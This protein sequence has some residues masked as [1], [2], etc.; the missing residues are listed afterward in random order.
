MI[1]GDKGKT[2]I[3]NEVVLNIGYKL[4]ELSR[5]IDLVIESSPKTS[6]KR[7]KIKVFRVY[8]GLRYIFDELKAITCSPDIQLEIETYLN[9]L[10]GGK[11]S[12]ETI[13]DEK[14]LLARV[15]GKLKER[16]LTSELKIDE[17]NE[18]KL[19]IDIWRN[20]ISG[21]LARLQL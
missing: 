14:R 21:D 18:L 12:K 15:K 2:M 17:V 5:Q 7:I 6:A 4:G 10:S 16:S 11:F 20:R 9:Q 8:E 19:K 13:D 1:Q 3:P